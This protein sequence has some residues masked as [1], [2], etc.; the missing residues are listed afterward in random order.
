M[1]V[2]PTHRV[3]GCSNKVGCTDGFPLKISLADDG[4]LKRREAERAAK[5]TLNQ[6][7]IAELPSL[8]AVE[9][10]SEEFD[11]EF[12]RAMLDKIIWPALVET[13]AQSLHMQLPLSFS[14]DDAHNEQFL[15]LVHHAINEVHFTLYSCCANALSLK[16]LKVLPTHYSLHTHTLNT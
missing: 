8:L 15:R 6:E 7:T 1:R 14:N 11:A 16:A 2:W 3:N 9:E 5:S 13:A 10:V 4:E 12:V